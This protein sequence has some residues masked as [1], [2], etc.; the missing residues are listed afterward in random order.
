MDRLTAAH[1]RVISVEGF[2]QQ[3]VRTKAIV[4]QVRDTV[5]QPNAKKLPPRFNITQLSWL[6]KVDSAQ[7]DKRLR[8]PGTNVPVG[9]KGSATRRYF[10][11]EDA[12]GWMR[13]LHPDGARPEGVDACVLVSANLKG[14]VAK[15]TTAV[16]LAHGL[17]LRGHRVLVIDLDP[18]A[19]ATSIF[20]L[21]PE[22]NVSPEQTLFA[23]FQG[24]EA[25]ADYAIQK[26]YWP[27]ID[28]VPASAAMNGADFILAHRQNQEDAFEF[29]NVLSHGLEN[30]RG[31]Y[32]VIVIDTPPSLSFTSMNG[33][34][35]ADGFVMPLPPR[36]ID[37][38]ASAQFW[39]LFEEM[40]TICRSPGR[41]PKSFA[42]LDVVLSMVDSGDGATDIVR[43]WIIAAYGEK[44]LPVEIPKTS[45]ASTAGKN[46]G[47]VYDQMVP[48]SA[49]ERSITASRTFKRAFDAYER[50]VDLVELHVQ[51]F[52]K[53][54]SQAVVEAA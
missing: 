4:D 44:V 11:V 35:A 38:A 43:E 1:Q 36:A 9:E 47:S 24:T 34:M 39:D 21:E 20:G 23:L 28:I 22:R 10:S 13:L 40:V 26:T 54:Q 8:R 16:T 42:F 14:G 31:N 3:A 37:F 53:L 45:A 18:Q 29:W 48:G 12:Q 7:L 41:P 46:F 2:H 33:L 19:S 50:L 5:L 52:W 25:S 17:S 32:D 49:K 30:A 15:T 27:G 51:D 6:T